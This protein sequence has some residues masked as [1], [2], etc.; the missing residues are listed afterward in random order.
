VLPSAAVSIDLP[1]PR[2]LLLIVA[3]F[4]W[5]ACG[6]EGWRRGQ[7]WHR[8]AQEPSLLLT[9][10]WNA[11]RAF[12]SREGD[13]HLY[14]EY[15]GLMLGREADLNYIA[16]KQKSDPTAALARIRRPPWPACGS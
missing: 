14:Y 11:F 16:G 15:A 12:V 2:T 1:R 13:D 7:Y 10:P 4:A 3:M 5:F 8:L 6:V 9:E